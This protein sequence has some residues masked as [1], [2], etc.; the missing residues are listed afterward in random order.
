VGGLDI[1]RRKKRGL[2]LR[3][4]GYATDGGCVFRRWQDSGP[5]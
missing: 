3:K 5:L 1:T 2:L 4:F